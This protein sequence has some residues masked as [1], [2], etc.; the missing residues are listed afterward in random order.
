MT[1]RLGLRHQGQADLLVAVFSGLYFL[2][3]KNP[4]KYGSLT[5]HEVREKGLQLCQP[6]EAPFLWDDFHDIRR[7]FTHDFVSI[8]ACW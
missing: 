1:L 8:V 3:L 4:S 2:A 6:N 7:N 5:R